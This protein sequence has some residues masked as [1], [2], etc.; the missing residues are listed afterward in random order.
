MTWYKV[1][2]NS[3]LPWFRIGLTAIFIASVALRFWGLGRFNNLVFDEV[4]YGIFAN[5]YLIG[6][7]FFNA[8]P[9]LSQYIIAIGMWIGSHLPIGQDTV[10]GLTGSLRSTW[11][12]R[13]L[14]ALTGS[15]IP[16]VVAAIAYQL[17]RRRSYALIAA[18][19]AAADGLFLVESRYALN[20]VYLVILGLLGQ[21]FFLIALGQPQKRRWGTLALAGIFF[22]AS[23][24]IKWNGLWFLLG[25]YM[26]WGTA[27]LLQWQAS[28][29]KG[30]ESDS[31]SSP[32]PIHA[33]NL[34]RFSKKL[35]HKPLLNLTQL[36]I[37]QILLNFALI[38]ALTYSLLWIPHLR[39]N[40]T[41]GF[42]QAQHD[43][44][45][46]HEK[47]GSGDKVHP[48]C[49]KWYTWL[50]MIRPIAYFYQ[51]AQTTREQV[52]A[53]PPLPSNAVR[54]IYDVHAMG[55]PILYWLST[56]TILLLLLLL[57]HRLW[58]GVWITFAPTTT[59][60]ITLYLVMNW[61]ANLLPWVKVTRCTFLYHYMGSSVFA[62][63]GLAWIVDR[64][65]HRKKPRWRN[66]GIIA[67]ALVVA[68]FI[69]WLPIY[70]GL[71]L[72]PQGYKLRM[73]FPSWI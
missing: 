8:H 4:Y 44:L 18:L 51:T 52:P 17:N 35:Y 28:R 43:I 16:L 6:K 30:S 5:N 54:V 45:A 29:I 23:A 36:N 68:A 3:S 42:W 20:N 50:L 34:S 21:L 46:F 31:L 57:I 7:E 11:S 37:F 55:N 66:A 65:L 38:P 19:F 9:P 26:V 62:G 25:V 56:A 10:N 73:W 49:A 39:M 59:N 53:Y 40:P 22:G 61:L 71:P 24:C 58:L 32:N 15:F 64:W 1:L 14:N 33:S 67:I 70:L 47:I 2:S 27:W 60:Y 13:W 41:P 63:L 12:Y 69:F 72:S 48:Y